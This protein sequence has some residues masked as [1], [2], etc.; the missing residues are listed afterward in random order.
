MLKILVLI[1]I[2]GFIYRLF[3]PSAKQ[4]SGQENGIQEPDEFIDYEEVN[5]DGE[6]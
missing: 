3:S 1:V 5:D 4:I 2:I 6:N